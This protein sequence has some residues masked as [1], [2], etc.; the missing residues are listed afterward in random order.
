[1][2]VT[3]GMSGRRS[4]YSS[5][6][7]A[8]YKPVWVENRVK[9]P[10]VEALAMQQNAMAAK[11]KNTVKEGGGGNGG[12][13]GKVDLTPKRMGDSYF[14]S[15]LP[16]AQ[17]PWLLD[18]YLNASGHIRLGSLLMDLDALAGVVAYKHTGDAVMTVTAA[19]DRIV[20]ERPLKEICDLE[21]SGHVTYATGRSSMEVSLKVAKAPRE[22]EVAKPENVLITCAFT[23]VSLDP[24][25]QK[26]VPVAPLV[27][28]TDEERAL[29]A[30]GEKNYNAKRA[31]RARSLLQQTPNDEES[32]LIH[33]MWKADVAYHN[34]QALVKRPSNVVNMKDT[35]L[36]TAL[37]M[38]P[39]FRNRHNFMIF[40]GY[41]LQQTFELAFCCA[42]ASSQTRPTFLSLDPSTFE[43]P[44]PVGSV[45]YLKAVVS[46]TDATPSPQQT[47]TTADSSRSSGEQTQRKFTKVQVRVDSKVRDVEHAS[48][49][50]TGV[51]NYTFLVERDIR[52]MPQSYSDYMIWVD[53]RRR[54]QSTNESLVKGIMEENDFDGIQEGVTE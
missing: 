35:V 8:T 6:A 50:P 52:V 45:L 13:K 49:K 23:M 37:I 28:E 7:L 43:N 38:Q 16:L 29:F 18:T 36:K 30:K 20:L 32:D 5:S 21:L 39:Q 2:T 3:A 41:L 54:A 44:V 15:I 31:L 33:E 10:W 19:V 17:D 51:F 9:M 1:M 34:P 25:T 46:Y 14:R 24:V 26:P 48:K 42:A 27:L 47:T 40:G 22:E 12:V 11:K 4:F 53:A